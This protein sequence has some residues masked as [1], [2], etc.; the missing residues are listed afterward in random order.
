MERRNPT[1]YSQE[2]LNLFDRY[3]HG[4]LDQAAAKLTWRRTLATFNKYL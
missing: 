3:V 2:L 1:D 4:E